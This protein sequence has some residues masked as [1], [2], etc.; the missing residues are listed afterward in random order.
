VYIRRDWGDQRGRQFAA[1]PLRGKGKDLEVL[2]VT[3]RETGRWV[4]P[5][6]W[7]EEG[8]TGSKLAAKEAFEEAGLL[9][10]VAAVPIG[11]YGYEKRLPEGRTT[12]CD[13]SVFTM[14][15]DRELEDWPEHHQRRRQWFPLTEAAQL[16]QEADLA[17]LMLRLAARAA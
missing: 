1:L 3:S 13:V 10:S 14:Q 9:G 2:L 12:P 5:K 15:V 6:G 11:T 7:A 8:L 4:L 16:V 17:E